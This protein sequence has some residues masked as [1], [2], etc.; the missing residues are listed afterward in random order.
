MPKFSQK[1]LDQ[2]ATCHFDL[3]R[4]AMEA[5]EVIDF[6]VIEGHRNEQRQTQ[7]FNTGHSRTPWPQSMHNQTPSLAFD[8]VP[9]PLNWTDTKNFQRIVGVMK[10]CAYQLGIKVRFGADFK[11]FADLGH[12]E[13]VMVGNET[14]N[15]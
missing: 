6:A 4:L 1:S 2:L 13:L 12:V 14:Q 9:Y 10:A 11:N 15:G 5:I 7:A 3:K 8:F